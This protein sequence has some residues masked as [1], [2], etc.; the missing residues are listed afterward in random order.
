ML[1]YKDIITDDEV[2]SDSFKRSPVTDADG[3]V[4]P[5]LFEVES[6]MIVVGG[7]NIDVGAGNAFGGAGEDEAVDDSVEKVNNIIDSRSGFGYN[8]MPL[9]KAE[10]KEYVKKYVQDL[11]AQ[12]KAKDTPQEKIKQFMAE[13]NDAFRFIMG[14]YSDLQFYLTRSYNVEAGLIYAYFKEGAATPTFIYF[15]HGLREEKF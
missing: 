7:D 5:A 8:E 15:T 10:L 6:R 11:R 4:V 13:A 1:V 3:N 2:M 9:S 12:L 14:K